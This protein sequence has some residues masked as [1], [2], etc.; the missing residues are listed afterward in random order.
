MR[1]FPVVSVGALALYA[2]A[3]CGDL[4]SGAGLEHPTWVTRPEFQF[5]NDPHRDVR[6]SQVPY[7]RV[8]PIRNRVFV[9]D[10]LDK[11]VTAWSPEGSVVFSAGRGEGPGEFIYPTR[12]YIGDDG[13][14]VVGE[15]LGTRF[16]W[17]TP[18][19]ELAGTVPGPP[20]SVIHDGFR[21][22]LEAPVSDGG[23]LGS[24]RIPIATAVGMRD[25]PPINTRPLLRVLPAERGVWAAPQPVFRV[26]NRNRYAAIRR[27]ERTTFA[28]QPFGDEDLWRIHPG[29]AVV[30]RRNGAPG[31]VDLIELNV[32]GDTL[33]RRSLSLRPQRLTAERV[34]AAIA[35]WVDSRASLGQ[36]SPGTLRQAYE[37]VLYRP[38]YLP[39]VEGLFLAASGEVWLETHERLDNL[40]VF[41]TVRRDDPAQQP[42]RIL[43]PDGVWFQDA[44]DTHVWGIRRD[45]LDVPH[46]V[47]RRLVP[48]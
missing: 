13:S 30:A 18:D 43:L 32:R 31:V 36:E 47:G 41:Y 45:E 33:W 23:F 21:L 1:H 19:G 48:R 4:H 20:T 10:L 2:V 40:R 39:A 34:E 11:P 29:G 17:Y 24:P 27:G 3:A 26:D 9:I 44:T 42:R 7:L 35:S 16:T 8:D 5:S 38:E 25:R 12:I 28:G 6:L 14:F 37:R 46:I 22:N 15:N